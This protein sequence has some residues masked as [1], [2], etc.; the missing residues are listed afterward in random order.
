[1]KDEGGAAFPRSATSLVV[2]KDRLSGAPIV[3]SDRGAP[4]MSMRQWYKGRAM[5]GL[6]AG[7]PLKDFPQTIAEASALLADAQ[8]AE[9]AKFRE[10]PPNL[11]VI[12][13]QQN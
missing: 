1:M 6:L 13:G 4:G 11:E 9:D 10:E 12:D 5:Q 2:G 3:Q 7:N 8:I